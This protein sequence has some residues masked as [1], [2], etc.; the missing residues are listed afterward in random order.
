[1]CAGEPATAA[2]PLVSRVE[3]RMTFK[4]VLALAF[5]STSSSCKRK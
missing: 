2:I 4:A 1:M 3:K 5:E